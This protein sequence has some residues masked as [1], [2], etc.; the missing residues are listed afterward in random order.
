LEL[1]KTSKSVLFDVQGKP[2]E[3]TVRVEF[4]QAQAARA[5]GGILFAFVIQGEGL[6]IADGELSDE[7]AAAVKSAISRSAFLGK[8]D[9]VLA[10]AGVQSLD[11]DYL[12]VSGLGP[13]EGIG[14]ATIEEAAAR[15]FKSVKDREIKQLEILMGAFDVEQATHAALGVALAAYKFDKYR[16]VEKRKPLPLLQVATDD[17]ARAVAAHEPLAALANGMRFARELVSEPPN[18][19]YPKS[20]VERLSLLEERGVEVTVLGETEMEK[21]GMGSLLAVG[22]GSARESQLAICRWSGAKDKDAPP[23]VLV[24]KGV[25][26]DSGGLSLKPPKDMEMMKMDMGGAAAVAGALLVLAER[27]AAANVIGVLGLVEN[28][29][30]GDAVR[31]GDIVTSM[32]GQT[33]EIVNTDAEGRLVLADALWF[34]QSEFKPSAMID[35]ATLTGHASYSLGNDYAALLSNDDAL[36]ERILRS[37]ATEAESI[38]RLPLVAAYDKLHDTPDADMK[39]VGGHPEAG[40]ITAALFIQRFV[41]RVPWAHLDIASVAWRSRDDR[42]I[43]PKGAT[44]FGV[45]TLNRLVS[46]YY[47][48]ED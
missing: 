30:D 38:W 3:E 23:L 26:F 35:L 46:D 9:E 12:V 6:A 33:I 21:L 20:F 4:V 47:E 2:G 18:I 10:I 34:A 31:P 40:A 14:T 43:W 39:N 27:K 16:T 25:T 41:N 36:S 29:P 48:N 44:G 13:R 1:Q 42:S 45:R 19:L 8:L 5:A 15:A 7:A 37:S 22:R 28:M 32:S 24:G 11:A 17:V